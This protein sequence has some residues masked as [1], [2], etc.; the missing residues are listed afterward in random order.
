MIESARVLLLG[1]NIP[2]MIYKS[3]GASTV[4][5]NASGSGIVIGGPGLSAANGFIPTSGSEP[6]NFSNNEE[7]WAMAS[8]TTLVSMLIKT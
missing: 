2:Q 4:L 5:F 3:V 6:F 1:N 7:L 8:S